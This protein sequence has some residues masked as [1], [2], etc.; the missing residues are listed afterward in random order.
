MNNFEIDRILAKD[1]I[2][3]TIYRGCYAADELPSVK[4][5]TK[6]YGLVLNTGTR[7]SGGRHWVALYVSPKNTVIYFDSLGLVPFSPFIIDFLSFNFETVTYST[8]KIQPFDSSLCGLYAVH[9]LMKVSRGISFSAYLSL[10]YS[11]SFWIN[12]GILI[13]DMNKSYM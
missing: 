9:F 3:K 7:A 11:E 8:Q 10:F 2:T 1:L 5:W 13:S 4:N 6:P 12:D